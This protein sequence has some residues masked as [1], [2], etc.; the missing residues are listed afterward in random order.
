MQPVIGQIKKGSYLLKQI[1]W[2]NKICHHK[3][4]TSRG[5]I[6]HIFHLKKSRKNYRANTENFVLR[7]YVRSTD[8]TEFLGPPA[9]RRSKNLI[10][11]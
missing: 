4:K 1:F 6:I 5:F 8:Q 9:V 7:T 3:P 10:Q 11:N 2:D